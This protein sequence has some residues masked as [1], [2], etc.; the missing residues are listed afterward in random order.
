MKGRSTGGSNPA[1]PP[2]SGLKTRRPQTHIWSELNTSTCDLAMRTRTA[3]RQQARARSSWRCYTDTNVTL[4]LRQ[5]PHTMCATH[6]R[7]HYWRRVNLRRPVLSR[8]L[9]TP[10]ACRA[11]PPLLRKLVTQ[12]CHTQLPHHLWA[13]RSRLGSL[14]SGRQA[15]IG[16][17][18][19]DVSQHLRPHLSCYHLG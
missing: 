9:P 8:A 3:F 2:F 19:F 11:A 5:C 16:S 18:L 4:V 6:R 17:D 14:R 7:T 12:G 15:Q 13:D 10:R 1:E